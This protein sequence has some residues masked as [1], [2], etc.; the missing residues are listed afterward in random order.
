MIPLSN[1]GKAV[2]LDGTLN[3]P[4]DQDKGWTIEIAIPWTAFRKSPINTYPPQQGDRWRVR[5][6]T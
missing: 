4:S 2:Y 5:E 6:E 1:C 3:D